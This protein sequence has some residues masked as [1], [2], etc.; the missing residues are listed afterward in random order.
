[1]SDAFDYGQ[2]ENEKE[3]EGTA[4]TKLTRRGI[5]DSISCG[6]GVK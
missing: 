1:M 2:N 6:K 3:E 5:A 4:V